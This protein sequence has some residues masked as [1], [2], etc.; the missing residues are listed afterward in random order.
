MRIAEVAS[1]YESVSPKQY[2]GTERIVSYL[3]EE[4]I[5]HGHD[6]TLFVSGDSETAA[7]LIPAWHRSLRLDERCIDQLA[8]HV[9]LLDQVSQRAHEFDVIHF[10]IDYLHVPVSRLLRFSYVKTLH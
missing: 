7:R 10:H 3:T 1:L 8:H 2:G 6:V 9:L 5:R 4:L